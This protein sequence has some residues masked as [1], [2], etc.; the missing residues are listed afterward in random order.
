MDAVTRSLLVTPDR[1]F[2]SFEHPRPTPLVA[3]P[4]LCLYPVFHLI[5][6]DSF[7]PSAWSVVPAS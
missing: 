5:V 1:T 3:T 7:N 4:P 2:Q 6:P